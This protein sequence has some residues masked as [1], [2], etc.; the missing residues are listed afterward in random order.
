[1]CLSLCLFVAGVFHVAQKQK[2]NVLSVYV[3]R[4]KE[5]KKTAN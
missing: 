4:G 1:V 5:M 2:R 3:F